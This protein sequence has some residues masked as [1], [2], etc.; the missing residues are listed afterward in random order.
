MVKEYNTSSSRI[1]PALRLSAVQIGTAVA[2]SKSHV[3]DPIRPVS[4]C[5]PIALAVGR[6][7]PRPCG[8]RIMWTP[9][10]FELLAAAELDAEE[11]GGAG[12]DDLGAGL[13]ATGQGGEVAHDTVDEDAAAGVG[14][15][16]DLFVDPGAAVD[17]AE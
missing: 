10:R 2:R 14:V 4:S 13:G 8:G 17:V 9:E 3:A 16:A 1:S 6:E 15:V 11:L 12:G 5:R 7:Q